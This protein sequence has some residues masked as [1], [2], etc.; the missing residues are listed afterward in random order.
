[1]IPMD[2]RYFLKLGALAFGA[3]TF[4]L[5]PQNLLPASVTIPN[6]KTKLY[7]VFFSD[8]PSEDDTHL[9]P[10]S[11]EV[12]IRRLKKNCTGVDFIVRDV[13]K[14]I[15]KETVLNEITDLK[16]LGYDGVIICG[17]PR[18]YN[19][20]RSGLP[21]INVS[22]VNDF[23]NVPFPVYTENKVVTAFLDPWKFSRST[24]IR[25]LM[26]NDLVG[27]I[28]L[29]KALKTFRDSTI[30][31]VTDSQFVN[32]IYG[33]VLKNP[34]KDYNEK[35]L[36]AIFDHLGVKVIK[37]GT[38]EVC[39]E[40]A[41]K[42]IWYNESK[43]ANEIA[44]TW[45]TNAKKMINTTEEEIVKSAKCYLAM[46]V[47]MKKYQATAMA[48]HIRTL[49][50]DPKPDELVYPA[51]A[52]SE[53]QR[54]GIVAKCQ[55]H[56]NIVLSEMALQFAFGVPSMLGDF[57]V[58]IYNNTSIV[59]HCE[60]P[61]NPWGGEKTVPYIITDHRERR[62]RGRSMSG[63]GAGSWILYPAD[64]PVTIWQLDVLRKEILVHTGKT[65]PIESEESLYQ[66]HFWEMM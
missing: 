37:I 14:S 31:T 45:I 61:W 55:S 29:I 3:N 25:D 38:N 21:T 10:V 59:Q 30:L 41:I 6:K 19:L 33:D 8:A 7:T 47:L 56:L 64:E 17:W 5:I 4:N 57:A 15:S 24:K 54:E 48:F 11:N 49:K 18:D 60:G 51:L 50:K 52:T 36:D 32:V 40:E 63:V 53:F 20:L 28:H 16:R 46:K 22:I 44:K 34:P 27:K 42:S 39:N 9:L 2:R 23:M 62:V 65:I 43:K 13:T 26:Y 35:I 66:R 12:I 1:M 58:D